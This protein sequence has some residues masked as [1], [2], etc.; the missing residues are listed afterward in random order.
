MNN[1]VGHF[2]CFELSIVRINA[3]K[4]YAEKWNLQDT[5]YAIEVLNEPLI[6]NTRGLIYHITISYILQNITEGSEILQ[7]Y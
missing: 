3:A 7:C 5:R 4:L 6:I 1:I 2:T